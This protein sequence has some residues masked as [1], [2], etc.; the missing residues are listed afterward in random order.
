M[1]AI[2]SFR[3][4]IPR[5][6][7]YAVSAAVWCLAGTMLCL[8]SWYW[9]AERTPS[10]FIAVESGGIVVAVVGFVFGFSRI[11]AKNIARIGSLPERS[12]LFA[13]TGLR[14]YALIALMMSTGILLRNSSLPR[15]YLSV[16]Y[17][18][19][20]GALLFGSAS[21]LRTFFSTRRAAGS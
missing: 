18:A 5:R 12:S 19:M 3:P 7:L 20:G 11:T 1:P 16:P 2:E 21:F 14:G 8:R 6:W 13:F 9:M 17:T 15:E 10:T 4:L